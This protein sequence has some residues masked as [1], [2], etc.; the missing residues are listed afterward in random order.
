MCHVKF[1]FRQ[2]QADGGLA[3]LGLLHL[4]RQITQFRRYLTLR[5]RQLFPRRIVLGRAK[6]PSK[7][8]AHHRPIGPITFDVNHAMRYYTA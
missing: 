7:G 1:D 2:H 5:F 8:A 6:P 3:G 4:Y